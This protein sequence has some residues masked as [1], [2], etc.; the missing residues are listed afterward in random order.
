MSVLT[1]RIND[2][3]T[4]IDN[5]DVKN[6]IINGG[7]DF[8]QRGNSFT[9]PATGEYLCDRFRTY[10]FG[11]VPN[12]TREEDVPSWSNSK[13]SAKVGINTAIA[14]P[15]TNDFLNFRQ[16][17]EGNFFKH[18]IGKDIIISFSVKSN[19]AGQHG[20]YLYTTENSQAS[21]N[22]SYTI[23]QADTWE[24][25]KVKIPAAVGFEDTFGTDTGISLAVLWLM[26]DTE[27]VPS[28]VDTWEAGLTNAG[29]NS[30]AQVG[31]DISDYWQIADIMLTEDTGE[32]DFDPDFTRAGRNYAEELQLCQRY[33]ERQEYTGTGQAICAGWVQSSGTIQGIIEYTFKRAVPNITTTLANG[34]G[35]V[36]RSKN[37]DLSI[38]TSGITFNSRHP[39]KSVMN[40]PV[41]N[42]IGNGSAG[43][44][45]ANTSGIGLIDIDA[46]L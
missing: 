30:N 10:Y 38:P 11:I 34:N 31:T 42:S 46:E 2:I 9:A 32:P 6:V 21:Y 7:F 43:H 16:L 33:F 29:N 18:L 36:F 26:T 24:R 39:E 4:R 44:F 14:S 23:N 17:I 28:A 22:T 27:A 5:K 41:A 37:A 12:I 19:K 1:P 3:D 35:L 13:Y 20:M 15:T 40:V 45:R 8:W 25:K